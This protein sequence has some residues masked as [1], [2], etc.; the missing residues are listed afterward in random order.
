MSRLEIILSCILALSVVANI[1][2]F[3]YARA[4][5]SRLLFVADELGDL[6]SMTNNFAKHLNNVYELE[7]FYGDPTLQYLLDHA[8]SFN[9]QL[10]TFEYIYTLTETEGEAPMTGDDVDA[11]EEDYDEEQSITA[12]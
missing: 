2:V 7:S 4:A 8:I 3:V 1:G 10:E 12:N 9:E 5:I 11:E 6:Q